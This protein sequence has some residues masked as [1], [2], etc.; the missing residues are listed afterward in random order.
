MTVMIAYAS[1]NFKWEAFG[2]STL[3]DKLK[4]RGV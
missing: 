3:D 2:F 1:T 4:R